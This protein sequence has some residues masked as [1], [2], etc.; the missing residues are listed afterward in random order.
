MPP[1]L[2]NLACSPWAICFYYFPRRYDDYS[3]LKPIRLLSYGEVVT[4]IGQ[5][6]SVVNR[7]IRGGKM[8]IIEAVISDG[9]GRAAHQLV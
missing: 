8:Q 5:I 2:K 7:P 3:K 4:V 9:T 6:Q 1:L